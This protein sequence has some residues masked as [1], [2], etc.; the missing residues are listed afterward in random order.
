LVDTGA[1]LVAL[2]VTDAQSAGIDVDQL[3]FN[4]IVSTAN[5]QAA[6]ASITLDEVRVGSIVRQ[7]VKAMVAR[8]L[9]NSLLG[10][11]FFSTLSKFQIENDELI[12]RD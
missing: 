10:M 9:S 11:S 3:E 6:A 7:D 4:R 12:L 2:S 1:T 8:G 5:G